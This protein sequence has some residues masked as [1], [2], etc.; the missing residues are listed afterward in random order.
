MLPNFFD[1]RCQLLKVLCQTVVTCPEIEM[2]L[3]ILPSQ[4]QFLKQKNKYGHFTIII[5]VAAECPQ[6]NIIFERERECHQD[7]TLNVS[8]RLHIDTVL[9]SSSVTQIGI[10]GKS[11]LCFELVGQLFDRW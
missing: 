3:Q 8:Y 11:S 4:R 7:S 2:L 5:A 6:D 1:L 9:L 10:L